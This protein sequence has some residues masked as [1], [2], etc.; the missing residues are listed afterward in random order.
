VI[1]HELFK[2]PKLKPGLLAHNLAWNARGAYQKTRTI[3]QTPLNSQAE[4]RLP[5]VLRFGSKPLLRVGK[6]G[7]TGGKTV[8]AKINCPQSKR[9]RLG[10]QRNTECEKGCTTYP[11]EQ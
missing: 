1:A 3:G 7:P 4:H 2:N 5:L 9:I 11:M 8:V 6:Q 10:R